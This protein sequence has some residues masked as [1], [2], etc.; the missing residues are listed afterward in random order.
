MVERCSLLWFC[1]SF[2]CDIFCR[3]YDPSYYNYRPGYPSQASHGGG[4]SGY[5]S[6]A[7]GPP[8]RESDDRNWY[9]PPPDD[10]NRYNQYENR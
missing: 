3:Y 1:F 7:Y 4:M 2:F 5:G 10:R 9:Y 6:Q 8:Q